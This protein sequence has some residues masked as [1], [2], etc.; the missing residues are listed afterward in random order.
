MTLFFRSIFCFLLLGALAYLSQYFFIFIPNQ[1]V[2]K[3]L[4]TTSI[5]CGVS[6]AFTTVWIALKST[7]IRFQGKSG[8]GVGLFCLLSPY[9]FS[10]ACFAIL[11]LSTYVVHLYYTEGRSK[12]QKLTIKNVE[13]SLIYQN[14]TYKIY[15]EEANQYGSSFNRYKHGFFEAY[16]CAASAPRYQHRNYFPLNTIE[17]SVFTSK[18]G[19]SVDPDFLL[20]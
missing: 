8:G 18:Y 4:I 14:C 11:Y 9:L 2:K 16:V 5:V 1:S 12:T 20:P 10:Y 19:H 15:I 17:V 3:D 13:K 7:K 6:I